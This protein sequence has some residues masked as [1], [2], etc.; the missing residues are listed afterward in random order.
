VTAGAA[1][2][3][4]L[5]YVEP[6]DGAGLI[7]F[8]GARAVPGV[9]EQTED[10]YRRSL[11]LPC[12]PGTVELRPRRGHVAATFRLADA[13]DLALADSLCRALL[14]LDHDPREV[15]GAL[16]G[17]PLLGELV[18]ATPG[19]R[20]PGHV[21]G[22]ELAV[23]AV[24]GQQVSVAGAT[25]LAGRLVS[26]HGE[27]LERPLGRVTHLFPSPRA[28][29]EAETGGWAMPRTRRR[30]LQAL[31]S[32]LN[33]GELRLSPGAEIERARRILLAL[34]GIGPWTASYVAMRALGDRDAFL[35]A[36]HGVRRGLERLG[37]DGSPRAAE[38]TA[39]AWRPW[40]AYAVQYLWSLPPDPVRPALKP[41]PRREVMP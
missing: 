8:L 26:A 9:E 5:A 39:E 41:T 20:V 16:G 37:L 34:P 4:R 11:R 13:D 24:L 35:P 30:A 14:D 18:R 28:L 2:E 22:P 3:R 7:A 21:D 32:A 25:T 10:V 15:T 38:R 33:G 36:D 29:S 27:P 12:G 17:D 19:R 1:I 31:A 40:R 6:L 23:R